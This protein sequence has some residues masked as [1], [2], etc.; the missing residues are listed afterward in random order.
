M[1]CD[2]AHPNGIVAWSML[3]AANRLDFE[4]AGIPDSMAELLLKVCG[5]GTACVVR[6]CS[7]LLEWATANDVPLPFVDPDRIEEPP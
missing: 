2:L 5:Q 6:N 1:P 4:P 7:R 3:V